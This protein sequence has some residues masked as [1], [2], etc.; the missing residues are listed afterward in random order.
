[1]QGAMGP[2]ACRGVMGLATELGKA[3]EK[4]HEKGLGRGNAKGV[5]VSQP[6]DCAPGLENRKQAPL[7]IEHATGRLCRRIAPANGF[8][9][10][11]A[12]GIVV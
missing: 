3:L 6:T 2:V 11:L 12:Q 4:R 5:G 1:M 10:S 8:A 9:I 7:P